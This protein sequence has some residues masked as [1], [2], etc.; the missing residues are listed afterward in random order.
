TSGLPQCVCFHLNLASSLLQFLLCGFRLAC[1]I[2]QA[3][4]CTL[5][6][7]F[8]LCYLG[9]ELC[10][11]ALCR[12]AVIFLRLDLCQRCAPLCNLL[13]QRLNQPLQLHG[14]VFTVLE[15][16]T[17][18]AGRLSL[19]FQ[20]EPAGL[21]LFPGGCHLEPQCLHSLAAHRF[22]SLLSSC[23]IATRISAGL[24]WISITLYR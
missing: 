7:G 6:L 15:T 2:S 10:T 9:L 4:L 8:Q 19:L 13:F 1:G 24:S 11:H 17:G 3:L 18:L 21:H 16:G 5:L 23:R 20:P 14:Q 22:F 12:A